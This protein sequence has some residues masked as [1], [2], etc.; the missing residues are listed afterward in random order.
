MGY[1]VSTI[2]YNDYIFSFFQEF[3]SAH[4]NVKYINNKK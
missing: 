1:L 2:T 4:K 3:T